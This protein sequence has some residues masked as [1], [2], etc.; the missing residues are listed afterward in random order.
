MIKYNSKVITAYLLAL[1]LSCLLFTAGCGDSGQLDVEE[2]QLDQMEDIFD[3]HAR[4]EPE[5]LT[6]ETVVARVNGRDILF[7]QVE[8]QISDMLAMY[9][10]DL[11][12][13][14]LER[15]APEII[16]N[17]LQNIVTGYLIEEALKDEGIVVDED[18]V[19]ARV[20]E[21]ASEIPGNRRLSEILSESG[22]TLDD[23]KDGLRDDMALQLLIDKQLKNIPETTEDEVRQFYEN[24]M[25]Q[26]AVPESVEASHIFVAFGR[27]DGQQEKESHLNTIRQLRKAILDGE[28]SFEDVARNQSDAPSAHENGSLGTIYQGQML[29]N[30]DQALFSQNVGEIGEPVETSYGYHIIRVDARSDARTLEFSEARDDIKARLEDFKSRTAINEYLQKLHSTANVEIVRDPN[31][32]SIDF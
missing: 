28:A 32:L 30:I 6:G 29:R 12:R 18:D 27:E 1:G 31:T 16:A 21:I 5:A 20:R 17:V 2:A 25:Q 11:P 22:I 14:E 3:A 24:N 13:E 10:E 4:E 7:S 26:F 8:T 19:I 23:F 9:S 15:Q